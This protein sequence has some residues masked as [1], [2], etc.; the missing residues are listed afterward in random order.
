MTGVLFSLSV[1]I[2]LGSFRQVVLVCLDLQEPQVILVPGDLRDI[3]DT[4]VNREVTD[5]MDP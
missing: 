5:L 1:T 2:V 4:Q 3:Q